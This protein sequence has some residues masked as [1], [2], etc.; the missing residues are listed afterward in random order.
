MPDFPQ[1]KL[2]ANHSSQRPSRIVFYDSETKTHRVG[3][4]EK[5]TL[6]MGWS[7]YVRRDHDP[8]FVAGDWKYHTD[9]QAFCEYIESLTA[10]KTT[11]YVVGHNVF[12]D[13]Q[14][15]GFFRWFQR[16][17]WTLDFLYDKGLTYI[18]VIKKGNRSIKAISTTN[19]FAESLE[20]LGDSLGFKKL[21]VSFAESSDAELAVYCKRDV[22]IIVKA[23]Q[24]W[25]RFIDTH[26]CGSFG[27]TRASQSFRAFRHRFLDHPIYIHRDETVAALER[28]AYIGGRTEAFQ[29]GEQTGGP[30]LCYDVNSMYP[31]VMATE[32]YPYQLIDYRDDIDPEKLAEFV[33]LYSVVAEVLLDTDEPAYGVI[34]NGKVIFPVGRFVAYLTTP[35]VNYAI[36]HGHL[37]DVKRAS[38]YRSAPL[39]KRYVTEFYALKEQFKRDN[40]PVNTTMVKIFLNSLYGKFGQKYTETVYEPCF[41]APSYMRL[42]DHDFVDG[43]TQTTTYLMNTKVTEL[44]E[45]DGKQSFTAIAAH[46]TEYAR[47]HLWSI[48]RTAGRDN[49]LYCDTDS[50]Y[51]RADAVGV[52]RLQL[53]DYVLGALSLDGE[54]ETLA[55]YG[56]KDYRADT[57]VKLK[58]VP[59]NATE[60]EPGKYSYQQFLRQPSHLRAGVDNAFIVRDVVKVNKRVY[61]KGVVSA[62]GAVQPHRLAEF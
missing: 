15:S 24:A 62:D 19:Y 60:L 46:V 28:A 9:Q 50:I 51:V 45:T 37:V 36:D 11:L 52:D 59:K 20:R 54:Y 42:T 10:A 44:G 14:V 58:G 35:G 29:I 34:R 43:S 13:L 5:H 47:L 49:V 17:G 61:D 21:K 57:T 41:D 55:I 12:F 30:F 38:F 6:K 26:D 8:D 40:D 27:M 33:R 56:A 23:F 16:W 31:F 48:I 25:I 18:C 4:I 7:Y 39:F 2:T 53:D 32:H 22:E 1:R 3:P